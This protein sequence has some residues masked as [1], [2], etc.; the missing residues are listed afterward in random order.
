MRPSRRALTL[1]FA[2]TLG[3]SGVAAGA[4]GAHGLQNL[5][6]PAQQDVWK[7]AA[8]YQ[9]IHA[10]AL[11]AVGLG[12][13]LSADFAVSQWLRRASLGWFVGTV[14]FSGSLYLVVLAALPAAGAITPIGGVLLIAGWVSL[15]MAALII[16]LP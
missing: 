9:L 15:L 16:R 5:V 12:Q 1:V 4:F 2:A 7:T 6:E 8:N 10:L 3:A 13:A 14:L 11:L